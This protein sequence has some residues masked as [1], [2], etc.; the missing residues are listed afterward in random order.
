MCTCTDVSLVFTC[1][2]NRATTTLSS[3]HTTALMRE[4]MQARSAERKELTQSQTSR[5]RSRSTV[6]ARKRCTDAQCRQEARQT[7]STSNSFAHRTSY[8]KAA[9]VVIACDAFQKLADAVTSMSCRVARKQW[10]IQLT[11]YVM[12]VTRHASFNNAHRWY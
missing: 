9:I 8:F 7:I 2:V 5:T 3:A 10:R 12:R 6:T 4:R 11:C 1:A